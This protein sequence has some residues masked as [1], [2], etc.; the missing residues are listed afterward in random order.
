VVN[1]NE[2]DWS[3]S[4]ERRQLVVSARP[5]LTWSIPVKVPTAYDPFGNPTEFIE[6]DREVAGQ[7]DQTQW[8]DS[9]L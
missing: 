3:L 9:P 2:Q 4:N 5:R 7:W 1:F 8:H 6:V